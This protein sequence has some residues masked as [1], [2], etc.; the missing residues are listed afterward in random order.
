MTNPLTPSQLAGIRA[1]NA[2]VYAYLDGDH[3]DAYRTLDAAV[4]AGLTEE[5][6]TGLLGISVNA[7]T[8]LAEQTGVNAL[9]AWRTYVQISPSQHGEQ[10][11]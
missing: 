5:V 11:P 9:E 8:M 1:V 2:A 10:A 7:L 6:V 3:R 4:A